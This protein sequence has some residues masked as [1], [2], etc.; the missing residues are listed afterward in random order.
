MKKFLLLCFLAIASLQSF[1]SCPSGSSEIIVY[2]VPD[3]WYYEVSWTI[4][5]INGQIVASGDSSESDTLCF[6]IGACSV[7]TIHDSYGD[8]I[9]APGGFYLYVDG[10]LSFSG[11]NF[12]TSTQT[13]FN[14][15]P[16]SFCT[17]P[18]QLTY[19]IHSAP[20]DNTWYVFTP[21]TTGTYFINTCG[22]NNCNT[23]IWMYQG[24]PAP[25]Y[26]EG[27]QG[28]FAF[29]D[30][31]SCG[32][33]A[34]LNAILMAG[35]TYYIRIGDTNDSCTSNVDFEFTY[36][37]GIRGCTDL[38]ACNYNPMATEDDSS[39]IYYP[40][41]LC[42]GPDLKIDSMEFVNSLHLSSTTAGTCDVAEG[43]VLG[44]GT[45]N[46]LEFTSRIH[47]VGTLDFYIGNQ[48][49]QPG[50]FNLVNC[51]GHAHYEGYG[52]Y[53]LFDSNGNLVPAGHKNGYCVID[54]GCPTGVGQYSCG[55]MGISHG[56]YDQYGAGTQCQWIDITD[57]PTG[58]YRVA[59]IINSKH[60]PDAMGHYE[61]NY[62]NNATQACIHI[63]NNPPAAP[64][65]NFLPN[66][67]PYVDCAGLPGGNAEADCNGVCGGPTV[68]GDVYQSNTLDSQDTYTYLDLL[69]QQA[70]ASTCNDLNH[71]SALTVYDAALVNWCRRS[72]PLHPGGSAHNHCNFP[73]N[74]LNPNETIML[75][76]SNV[77]FNA[78]Y[79]DVQIV[80]PTSNVSA[81]QF[82][83]SGITISSVVSLIN[84]NNFPVDARF[85]A[86]TNEVV[87]ISLEDS[88]IVR[89][90]PPHPLIRIYFSAITDTAI[91]I[92]K[93][94][95]VVN[96]N[97]ER[98]MTV[99]TGNCYAA[100]PTGIS[101]VVS[102]PDLVVIPNPATDR[103]LIHLN[104]N[105]S[106]ISSIHIMD[107]SGKM[108]EVP[109]NY[110]K[111]NWYE[112]NLENL[113]GGVYMITTSGSKGISTTKLVKY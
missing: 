70:P 23:R 72:G 33:Q 30:S 96:S 62:V 54:V 57:V 91:C 21:D 2:I 56:C 27:V 110:S 52:D 34:A 14:C 49:T 68:F 89:F 36:T 71:D 83:M 31:S 80:N 90:S 3:S 85:I 94:T 73:R 64:T 25:P 35:N 19:G 38:N 60:L 5:D 74:I 12:G 67:T 82:T 10:V 103:A 112:M 9:S 32:E 39:C 107:M 106:H 78:G 50:M 99:I 101:Q 87:A 84:P 76:I 37:G 79:V 22:F 88:S 86:A 6:P 7:F 98:V 97:A 63:E 109:M 11:S 18:I 100:I 69:Q 29:N 58:D 1:S 66:C 13:S 75:S 47:N 53:R 41:P 93:I 48:S 28:T 108:F 111:D 113:P 26:Q 4:T 81:Y 40:S 15:P 59:V 46:V 104:D 65:F 102:R 42:A 24:C 95:D 43:C 55:N 8:G 44:Y 17:S 61:T 105:S 20:Y 77:N 51:H 16:G 45:R 92:S